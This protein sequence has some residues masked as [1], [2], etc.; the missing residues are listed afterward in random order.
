MLF[1][2]L[3]IANIILISAQGERTVYSYAAVGVLQFALFSL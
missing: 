3:K 1:F 2:F